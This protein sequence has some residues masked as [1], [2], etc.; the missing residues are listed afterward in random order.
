[1]Y[2]P[3]YE[4]MD[5]RALLDY[6][7][8]RE[9]GRYFPVVDVLHSGR[10]K[11]DA[12]LENRV[13]VAGVSYPLAEPLNWLTGP[14]VDV[15]WPIVLHEFHFAV[16]MGLAF[17][18]TGNARYVEKWITLTDSWIEQ[19]SDRSGVS[20][21]AGQRIQNW[22]YAYFY[23][24]EKN[25]PARIPPEF[26]QRFL[27]SLHRQ[28]DDLI[29]CL[30]AAP[31]QRAHDLY[32]IFLFAAVFPEFTRSLV[33]LEFALN[34][35][36]MHM[37]KDLAGDEGQR[38][39]STD[40][41]H[42]AIRNYLNIRLIAKL[43]QIDIPSRIDEL[44]ESALEF[45]MHMH[46]PDGKVP[47]PTEGGVDSYPDLLM[48]GYNLYGRT[49]MLYVATRGE[50]G[51]APS[52]RLL[53]LPHAGYYVTR[54][55]WGERG[56]S[57]ADERHLVSA[58]GPRGADPHRHFDLLS[59]EIYAYGRPLLVHPNRFSA[60]ENGNDQEFAPSP[61]TP[62][63]NAVLVDG[64]AQSRQEPGK[65][66]LKD[67]V[68]SP[69]HHSEI[70]GVSSSGHKLEVAVLDSEFNLLHGVAS[71]RGGDA[72]HQR[73]VAFVMREYWVVSDVLEAEKEHRYDVMFHLS[74]TAHR[75]VSVTSEGSACQVR[76]PNLSIAQCGSKQTR[77]SVESRLIP[78]YGG[79]KQPAPI[80][81]FTRTAQDTTFNTVLYPY[82]D[83]APR[84]RV[85]QMPAWSEDE[86]A[87]KAHSLRV[88]V[89][90]PD[91]SFTD[92]LFYA[93]EGARHKWRFGRFSFAGDYL[94][95]RQ[96]AKGEIVRLH[97]NPGALLEE[98]F[99]P[100]ASRAP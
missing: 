66:R 85:W 48:L 42:L 87:P 79:R 40:G 19:M 51:V 81:S 17:R 9:V 91:L 77:V 68:S 71:R 93:P 50:C 96:N 39:F 6:F 8:H 43:N 82:R 41:R 63:S 78:A 67:G 29:T 92:T 80:V 2:T 24:V 27:A 59:L 34:Q 12:M 100:V 76:A 84:I 5:A 64:N 83:Q 61:D 58:R 26:H 94:A 4:G 32:A 25:A 70:D 3:R 36:V 7:R 22:I 54:S 21:A 86:S 31:D 72:V 69:T 75:R 49:D 65:H 56:E 73:S 10:G 52:E 1:M 53:A 45:S 44:L 11:T 20:E 97:M 35:I 38:E 90:R 89:N 30:H 55:G 14:R 99:R 18:E 15:Q 28:V 88:A 13:E 16:G 37:E 57:Y 60:A 46:R 33:W 23:F 47:S 62:P 98:R 74:A 95:L